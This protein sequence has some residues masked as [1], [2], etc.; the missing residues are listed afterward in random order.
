MGLE[1]DYLFVWNTVVPAL[2]EAGVTQ[3]QVDEILVRNPQR[4]FA[5]EDAG[6]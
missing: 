2:L 4:F 6:R 1:G 5:P 3:D